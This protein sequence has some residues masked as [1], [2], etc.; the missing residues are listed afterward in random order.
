MTAALAIDFY[1]RDVSLT[2]TSAGYFDQTPGS[3]TFGDWIE[4][5]ESTSTIRATVQPAQGRQLQDM[6]EGVRSEAQ[7]LI[8]SRT[9]LKL[10]DTI[11]KDGKTYRVIH[12]W[13]RDEGGFY[14]AAMGLTE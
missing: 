9:E 4:G 5:G 2:R 6:P 11:G 3:P 13:P 7:W 1:A 10:D 8:W 12:L 14:R